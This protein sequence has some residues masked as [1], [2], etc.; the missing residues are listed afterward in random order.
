MHI[1]IYIYIYIYR[2]RERERDSSIDNG[3]HDDFIAF[4]F[5]AT[6]HECKQKKGEEEEEK[7]T[8]QINRLIFDLFKTD[9]AL[10]GHGLALLE[11]TLEI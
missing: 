9:A 8:Y 1:Y 5:S 7:S 10:A 6:K 4:T 2:E 11:K 3:R